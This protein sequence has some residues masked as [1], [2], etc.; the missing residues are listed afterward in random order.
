MTTRVLDARS[1]IGRLV[2]RDPVRVDDDATLARV[3]AVM[4]DANVSSVLVGTNGAIATER[5]LTRALAAGLSSETPILAVSSRH[6][7]R[8]LADLPLVD[9]AALMLNE[10]V[11]HLVIGFPDGSEGVVSLRDIVAVL[12]QTAS[13]ELW[14]SSLRV[15]VQLPTELWLG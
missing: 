4:R 10:E 13:P 6:P 7:V 12:L 3:A 2:S 1:H 5:D 9:G 11:R 15:S 14:L 8:V